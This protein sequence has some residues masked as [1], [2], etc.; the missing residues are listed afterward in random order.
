MM[1]YLTKDFVYFCLL[2]I[3]LILM[4]SD[5]FE[6]RNYQLVIENIYVER[7]DRWE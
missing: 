1:V 6:K 3:C 2:F 4:A 7:G 5:M